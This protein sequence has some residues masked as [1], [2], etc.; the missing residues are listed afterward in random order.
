MPEGIS[1]EEFN[2]SLGRIHDKIDDINKTGI[3]ID[4]SAKLMK[5]SVD[6]IYDCVY[7]TNGK[8]G[9]TSRIVQLF[10]RVSLH[11]KLIMA[12]I[13]SILSIAFFIIQ[14]SLAK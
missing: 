9:L 14:Q 1:R 4:T 12:I 13:F 5:E 6:K 7:G 3:Q 8:T 10:E 11:T 2:Q